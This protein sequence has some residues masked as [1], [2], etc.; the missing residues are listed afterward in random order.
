[1][2]ITKLQE[3]FSYHFSDG[4]IISPSDKLRELYFELAKDINEIIKDGREKDIILEKL[5]EALFWSLRG[6]IEEDIIRQ[7]EINK[8]LK[9]EE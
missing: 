8:I 2:K 1:M 4:V 3:H 5:Q 9:G 7:K 6:I